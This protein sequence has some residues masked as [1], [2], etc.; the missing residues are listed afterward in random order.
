M[1]KKMQKTEVQGIYKLTEGILINKD[2]DA[3]LKYKKRRE[4]LKNKDSKM[5][6][7]ETKVDVLTKDMEEIKLLLRKLT[8][9]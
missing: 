9:E 4:I 1:E 7:L 2:N 3:L 5:I 8:K 6:S